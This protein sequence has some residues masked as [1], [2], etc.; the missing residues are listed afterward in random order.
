MPIDVK[1]PHFLASLRLCV[2]LL[3]QVIS[4]ERNKGMTFQK[5]E[6]PTGRDSKII[7]IS[8]NTCHVAFPK[9]FKLPTRSHTH[10]DSC[11]GGD[12]SGNFSLGIP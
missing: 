1:Q 5:G 8:F 6:V 4:A 10:H 12:Q 7:F 9:R 11:F 2:W 3:C